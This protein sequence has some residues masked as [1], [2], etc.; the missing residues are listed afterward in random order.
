MPWYG[1]RADEVRSHHGPIE[2]EN[3]ERWEKR[4]ATEATKK[5]ID[6]HVAGLNPGMSDQ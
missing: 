6:E 3:C 5:L 2:S 1:E 4:Q